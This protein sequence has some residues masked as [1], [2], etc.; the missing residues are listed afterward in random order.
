MM[1]AARIAASLKA[2]SAGRGCWMACCPAHADRTP[3]LSICDGEDGRVLL[4]CHAGC[5]ARDVIAELVQ[6]GLWPGRV[7][8]G[9]TRV[10]PIRKFARDRNRADDLAHAEAILRESHPITGT[11]AGRYLE[12]RDLHATDLPTCL[13]FHPTLWHSRTR[14]NWP[15]MVAPLRDIRTN[16]I[17]GVHRTY[18][19]RDGRGKAPIEPPRM[20]LGRRSGAVIKL[21]PDEEVAEGLHIG[22]GIETC[23]ACIEL[24]FRPMWACIAEGGIR[25]FPVLSGVECLTIMADHD[26]PGLA[27]AQAC[28]E[29]WAAAGKEVFVRW[30]EGLGRDYADEVSR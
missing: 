30:P 24:S 4:Y 25:D 13:R 21:T 20:V 1:T 27:A 18:L 22:E 12:G 14:E 17:T 7:R 3:S 5:D 10:V 29:R 9:P 8:S 28:A 15:A 19:A 23:V 2:K 6:R 26:R 16:A 11:L